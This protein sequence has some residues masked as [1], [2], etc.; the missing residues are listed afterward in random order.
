MLTWLVFKLTYFYCCFVRGLKAKLEVHS[1]Q[2]HL[3]PQEGHRAMHENTQLVLSMFSVFGLNKELQRNKGSI[4]I[5][6]ARL[7]M[8][9]VPLSARLRFGLMSQTRADS[10]ILLGA[11]DPTCA[12]ADV[13]RG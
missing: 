5:G 10:G 4:N 12:W 1:L 2:W 8:F 6:H 9:S 7:W 11:V 13:E 3:S